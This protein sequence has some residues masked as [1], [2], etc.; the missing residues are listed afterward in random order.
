[1]SNTLSNGNFEST[2]VAA[3]TSLDGGNVVGAGWTFEPTTGIIDTNDG[4][5]SAY[6][7]AGRFYQ[8]FTV[9]VSGNYHV[10][11]DSK[12]ADSAV[13]PQSIVVGI[14]SFSNLG[15]FSQI[16]SNFVTRTTGTISLVSG[17][18]H[19]LYFGTGAFRPY[20]APVAYVDNIQI[21][22]G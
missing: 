19:R 9:S 16:S 14:D 10:T 20:W 11:F 18:T 4:N 22:Q 15:Q 6:I 12:M 3:G 13:A 7:Q 21:V 8:D 2:N 1:M 5:Q 17:Q